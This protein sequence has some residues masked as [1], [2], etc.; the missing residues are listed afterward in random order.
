[1]S[2]PQRKLAY[3]AVSADLLQHLQYQMNGVWL[4]LEAGTRVYRMGHRVYTFP[5]PCF[6]L[7][8]DL[9]K[10]VQIRHSLGDSFGTRLQFIAAFGEP[11]VVVHDQVVVRSAP[12][13]TAEVVGAH[14]KDDVVGVK[15]REGEWVELMRDS[16]MRAGLG[17]TKVLGLNRDRAV[18]LEPTELRET[19]R[20]QF[21][22]LP[23]DS[24]CREMWMRVEHEDF[25]QL[26]RRC[27]KRTGGLGKGCVLSEGR[28]RCYN[29]VVDLCH[30][31][32]FE[33]NLDELWEG[34]RSRLPSREVLE[35]K[36][37]SGD[38]QVIHA[39]VNAK[40]AGGAIV[41]EIRVRVNTGVEFKGGIT[42]VGYVEDCAAVERSHAGS[43][44]WGAIASMDFMCVAC[45]SILLQGTVDFWRR[46]GFTRFDPGSD[47]SCNQFKDLVNVR[48]LGKVH[49]SLKEFAKALPKSALPLFIY[50]AP[51]RSADMD[52]NQEFIFKEDADDVD[53]DPPEEPPLAFQKQIS[54]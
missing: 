9:S 7:T 29:E 25:G 34:D 43:E 17:K 3:D 10:V 4:R 33:D 15:R 21:P 2:L 30:K 11:W 27:R 49:C 6:A 39:K 48:T 42:T 24:Q 19:N 53:P 23:Q 37:F 20:W 36:L 47:A 26:L 52:P 35:A 16:E 8:M 32:I 38:I 5:G 40:F 46:R 12:S 13:A 51:V 50:F 18:I 54:R 31:R 41:K 28:L 14:M 1:M 44:I 45:H 22:S